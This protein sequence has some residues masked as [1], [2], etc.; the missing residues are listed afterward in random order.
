MSGADLYEDGFP[1]STVEGYNRGCRGNACPGL[2]ENG[3]SCAQTFSRFNGDYGFRKKVGAG[4]S[5]SEIVAEEKTAAKPK[6][7][8]ALKKA[9]E[10]RYE[11]RR[12]A[13]FGDDFPDAGRERAD[14]GPE[15]AE[16]LVETEAIAP[17]LEDVDHDAMSFDERWRH[18]NKG[19][20][21]PL[22]RGAIAAR[23]RERKAQQR[24][25]A[26]VAAVA[27]VSA[28]EPVWE[29]SVMEPEIVAEPVT[30]PLSDDVASVSVDD[31]VGQL[32]RV[33]AQLKRIVD[34]KVRLE[35]ENGN[36]LA[37]TGQQ[38]GTIL[39]LREQFEQVAIALKELQPV[40][41]QLAVTVQ[42]TSVGE[43]RQLSITI[44]VGGPL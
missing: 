2:L 19:C 20:R 13:E 28:I 14:A 21:H 43:T 31:L 38:T 39:E 34:E 32:E 15:A 24:E 5:A 26:V 36:L 17:A 7:G 3:I 23:Q 8:E 41:E 44:T 6:P 22:C 42:Q 27:A 33:E 25:S 35:A 9:R 1:H 18:Y 12:L 29:R 16:A 4:M 37:L 40:P 30:E 11:E 10:A